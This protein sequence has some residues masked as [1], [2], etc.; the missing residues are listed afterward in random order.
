ML[1]R[2]GPQNRKNTT[3]CTVVR[4]GSSHGHKLHVQIIGRPFVKR[5][6]SCLSVSPVLSVTFRR[7]AKRLDGSRSNLARR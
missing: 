5:S 2:N 6:V 1:R 7:V 4:G 3:Y